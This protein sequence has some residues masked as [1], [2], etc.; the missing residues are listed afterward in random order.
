[1]ERTASPT[2]AAR[3]ALLW[4]RSHPLVTAIVAVAG[5]AVAVFLF[6]VGLDAVVIVGLLALVAVG[7]LVLYRLATRRPATTTARASGGM[8]LGAAA[9]SAVVVF[10]LIQ[11]VPYGRDHQNPARTGEPQW[12]SDRTRELMV[13]ACYACHSSEVEYPAYA[14]IAPLSWAIQRHIDEGRDAVNYSQFATD[15]G[16]A[17]NT[18]EVVEEGE[19]PPAFYTRF[20]RHPEAK[21]SRSELDELIT[22]LRATPGMSE[23]EGG[24][25]R[26][27][28]GD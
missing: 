2:R 17:E 22:G 28:D 15:Q 13:N 5:L 23:G 11:L 25:G 19:M 24:E 27:R 14:S 9:V 8:A 18:L 7:A 26:G 21:L 4:V 16:E 10:G 6:L 3:A 12:A 1:M 20:G